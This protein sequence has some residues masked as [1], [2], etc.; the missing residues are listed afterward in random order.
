MLNL[1]KRVNALSR[2]QPY[3]CL[4]C[5]VQFVIISTVKSRQI[6]NIHT[7]GFLSKC[8]NDLILPTDQSKSPKKDKHI[9]M[10]LYKHIIQISQNT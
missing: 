2:T 3:L 1:S 9:E 5:Y 4:K 7:H 10:E 6:S 8:K